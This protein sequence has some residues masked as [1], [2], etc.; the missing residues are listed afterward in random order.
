MAK[1]L[2]KNDIVRSRIMDSLAEQYGNSVL[3]MYDGKLRVE[4]IDDEGLV[5]QFSIAP[6]VHKSLVEED[7]CDP[8]I[9]TDDKIKEYQDSLSKKK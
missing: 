1:R 7:Q 4:L 5:I 8:Y 2:N 3:G 6:I 9:T